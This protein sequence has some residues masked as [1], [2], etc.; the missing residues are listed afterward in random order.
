MLEIRALS[1]LQDDSWFTGCV[2][3]QMN[4]E[5][6][7]QVWA[8]NAKYERMPFKHDVSTNTMQRSCCQSKYCILFTAVIFF[9]CN[10]SQLCLNHWRFIKLLVMGKIEKGFLETARA[11]GMPF[12]YKT[13][14]KLTQ[15]SQF[16][17][18]QAQIFN[19][20]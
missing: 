18:L 4:K 11:V 6:L 20:I 9:I 19:I 5:L 1:K 15:L 7:R 12:V 17:L 2:T 10:Q 14:Q 8:S 16:F 3:F 13:E